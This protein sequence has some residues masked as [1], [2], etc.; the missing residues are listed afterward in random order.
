MDREPWLLVQEGSKLYLLVRN[1]Q[2]FVFITVNKALTAEKEAQLRRS[3]SF[4]NLRLQ[5]LGLTFR[6]LPGDQIRGVALTGCEAGETLYFYPTSG[7]KQK[8]VFSDDYEKEQIDAFFEG[9]ER[10]T[11]PG[12]IRKKQN[13]AAGDWR[14]ERQDPAVFKKME[15]VAIGLT[16]FSAGCTAGYIYYRTWPWYLGCILAV[17][18]AIALDIVLPQYLTLIPPE[19]GKSKP[20]WNLFWAVMAYGIPI[21][22]MPTHNW[23]ME[24]LWWQVLIFCGVMVT[25][26]LWLWAEEFRR[27]PRDL[28]VACFFAAVIGMS[29]VGH[30]NEVFDFSE[31]EVYEATVEDLDQHRSRRRTSYACT[32][33]MPDGTGMELNISGR[34][35]NALE[36]GDPVRVEVSTGALG[37]EYAAAQPIE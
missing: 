13:K 35:Y 21:L 30:V 11:A 17:A 31:P 15:W 29:M 18:A 37:I 27:C 24:H 34:D 9:V 26:C 16:I 32:V 3:G 20:A 14:T 5:E 8:Y 1:Q 23:L 25:L 4:S 6:V 12:S 2:D 19:K 28:V 10:F 36:I 33:T 7:K 22:L